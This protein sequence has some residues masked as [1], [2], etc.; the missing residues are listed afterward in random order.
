MAPSLDA[1][2]REEPYRLHRSRRSSI[3]SRRR[4]RSR[5][6]GTMWARQRW[7]VASG[8]AAGRWIILATVA[9]GITRS[10]TAPSST[11]RC[12]RSAK[13]CTP[14][15]PDCN[16]RSMEY[17]VAHRLAR[18]RWLIGACLDTGACSCS[19]S[20]ASRLRRPCAGRP[21]ASVCSSPLERCKASPARC[22]FRAA[23]PSSPPRFIPTIAVAPSAHGRIGRR[24]DRDRP[25]PGRLACRSSVV[26]LAIHF[27]SEPSPRCDC[28][29]GRDAS[30][31]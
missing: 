13:T 2:V 26:V 7:G 24:V 5:N 18:S 8:S 31:P 11:L 19:G 9:S 10:S 14:T 20:L 15:F 4:H 22:W 16:G 27:L 29:S 30:R 12:A 23:S 28:R 25:V 6:G 3:G 1:C 21:P 17:L